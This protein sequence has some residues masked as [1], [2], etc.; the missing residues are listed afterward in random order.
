MSGKAAGRKARRRR[1][2]QARAA[3]VDFIWVITHNC[4]KPTGLLG[5]LCYCCKPGG[6]AQPYIQPKLHKTAGVGAR[7]VPGGTNLPTTY[8]ASTFSS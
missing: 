4:K 6:L 5:F 7:T 2:P 3:G 1:A 8:N